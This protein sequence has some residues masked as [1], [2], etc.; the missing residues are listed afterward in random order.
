MKRLP[1][2]VA[3][4]GIINRQSITSITH[5]KLLCMHQHIEHEQP[6]VHQGSPPNGN[7]HYPKLNNLQNNK[8]IN[9]MNVFALTNTNM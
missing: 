5:H 8:H 9:N 7:A 3:L 4:Y 6:D 2:N 1:E